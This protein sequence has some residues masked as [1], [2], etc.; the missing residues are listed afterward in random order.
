VNRAW[1]EGLCLHQS[2]IPE[3]EQFVRCPV[4][5]QPFDMGDLDQVLM[6]YDHQLSAD[7]PR[8]QEV[9]S[10]DKAFERDNVIPFNPKRRHVR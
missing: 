5:G 7:A 10:A 4:C 8:A 2:N 6:H 3:R 9:P 1:W